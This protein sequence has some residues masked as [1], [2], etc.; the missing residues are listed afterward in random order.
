MVWRNI[1]KPYTVQTAA[2]FPNSLVSV[3]AFLLESA[4]H[5]GA[6]RARQDKGCSSRLGPETSL[7]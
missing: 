4:H 2:W 5:L 7:I 3:E 6:S 1:N